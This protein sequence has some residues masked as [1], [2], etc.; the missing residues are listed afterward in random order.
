M[1]KVE[2]FCEDDGALFELVKIDRKKTRLPYDIWVDELGKNRENEYNQPCLIVTDEQYEVY[3]SISKNSQVLDGD[4][5][6][7]KDLKF[8][9]DFISENYFAFK[10]H[11]DGIWD[12]VAIIIY[13]E[14]VGK[15][16]M[17]KEDAINK[18]LYYGAID[19]SPQI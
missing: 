9:K 1:K 7:L 11:W 19:E 6:K 17:T 5:T 16:N 18:L 3:L 15:S 13:C 2:D 4:E 8:V 14:C 10:L 12:Y